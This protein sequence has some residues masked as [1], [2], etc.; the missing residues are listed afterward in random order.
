MKDSRKKFFLSE[1]D[2]IAV[3]QNSA[4]GKQISADVNGRRSHSLSHKSLPL[5]LLFGLLLTVYLV[6]DLAGLPTW[7]NHM[8]DGT[9]LARTLDS[10]TFAGGERPIRRFVVNTLRAG[11]LPLW[12]PTQA[13]GI[14][15]IEQYEYQ[16]FNPLEWLNWLGSDRWWT[17]VLCVE[18]ALAGYGVYLS[19]HRALGLSPA[20]ALGGSSVYVLTGFAAWFYTVP[21]FLTT[22]VPLPYI[23]F[24]LHRLAHNQSMAMSS[25]GFTVSSALILLTGQPQIIF[26]AALGFLL[27]LALE[28]GS[29][30]H[31]IRES[32]NAIA[33]IG[34]LV[35]F[36]LL[37]AAPQ[38]LPF[39]E[40]QISGSAYSMHRID[41]PAGNGWRTP[42]VNLF[43]PVSPYLQGPI[44]QWLR[45]DSLRLGAQEDFGLSF[46]VFGFF[47]ILLGG[48]EAF[49]LSLRPRDES[50]D[51]NA[52]GAALTPRN[53]TIVLITGLL[54]VVV[55]AVTR[56]QVW[57]FQ[58]VN[59][60]RYSV[61]FLS[62]LGAVM[63]AVGIDRFS[64]ASPYLRWF[65]A[66]VTCA[67]PAVGALYLHR[68]LGT[69]DIV[70]PELLRHSIF[71][72][73]VPVLAL[74]LAVGLFH[75]V[76][77]RFATRQ[78]VAYSLA[79]LLLAEGSFLV[80]YGLRLEF[81]LWRIVP[82]G[83]L[84]LASLFMATH[85]RSWAEPAIVMAFVVFVSG[86]YYLSPTFHYKDW[87][88][89][90]ATSILFIEKWNE[91]PGERSR[92]LGTDGILFPNTNALYNIDSF[93]NRNP[94]ISLSL[95]AYLGEFLRPDVVKKTQRSISMIMLQGA[96][97]SPI[98][99]VEDFSQEPENFFSWAEYFAARRFFNL[100]S[101]DL[102]VDAQN[103]PLQ[104][105]VHLMPARAGDLKLLYRDRCDG[106]PPAGQQLYRGNTCVVVLE[107]TLAL[108]RAYFAASY[109]IVPMTLDGW[110]ARRWLREHESTILGKPVA[111]VSYTALPKFDGIALLP[112]AGTGSPSIKP[113]KITSYFA[114]EVTL[115]ADE[116]S[117]GLVVLNDAFHEKWRVYVNGASQNVIRVNS[118]VRGVF[119][120][121]GK[122]EIRFVFHSSLARDALLSGLGL[123]LLVLFV[124]RER[125]RSIKK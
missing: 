12:L 31:P 73:L 26:C 65:C 70:S 53:L 117:P 91:R 1:V 112:N 122:N 40:D 90:T 6:P 83:L 87:S 48:V 10:T 110:A 120:G 124:A 96:D 81:D 62:L 123:G 119:V 50:R 125:R 118:V 69:G 30:G 92:I 44:N 28:V 54:L 11:R 15:V 43:N 89:P 17:L 95:V 38:G 107:D 49:I 8:V 3:Q 76:E 103:G 114:D 9:P 74:L 64:L 105:V 78:S 72:T 113:M 67:V 56:L 97:G 7:P 57:P 29:K 4:L 13:L 101:I 51:V 33:I 99:R 85:K 34:L 41:A 46:G 66:S 121:A 32:F 84:V 18:M 106:I 68:H 45:S 20:A 22:L 86:W 16:L 93:S 39:V 35:A 63:V 14:P 115:E 5:V 59:V 36:A 61:P 111:E 71:L 109:D 23:F 116:S 60:N 25:A 24:F 80:R 75:F 19:A 55:L 42:I 77:A 102:L 98:R 21:S 100:L 37:I 94:V 52:A 88:S 58:F 108:P 47:L 27:Y 104:S 82:F 79:V 2:A